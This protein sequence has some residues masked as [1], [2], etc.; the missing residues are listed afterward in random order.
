[1]RK[2]LTTTLYPLSSI[3]LLIVK[4]LK[5]L[6]KVFFKFFGMAKKIIMFCKRVCQN[7]NCYLQSIAT[8]LSQCRCS[9]GKKHYIMNDSVFNFDLYFSCNGKY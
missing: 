4:Y 1:M 2:P 9:R 3:Y 7:G 6:N 5:T 8:E